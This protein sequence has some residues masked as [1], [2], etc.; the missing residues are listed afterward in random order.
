MVNSLLRYCFKK[1]KNVNDMVLIKSYAEWQNHCSF[2]AVV[3]S[4]ARE[5]QVEKCREKE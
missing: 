2:Y 5:G 3:V 4:V 1:K